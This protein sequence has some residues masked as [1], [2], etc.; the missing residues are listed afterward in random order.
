[1]KYAIYKICKT[2][3]WDVV[4]EECPTADNNFRPDV[5]AVKNNRKIGFEVQFSKISPTDLQDRDRKYSNAGI[6]SYW[7]LKDFFG[8]SEI[9]YW[10]LITTKQQFPDDVS[11]INDPDFLLD[12][13][14]YYF[15]MKN[16]RSIGIDDS[17][18]NL[19]SSKNNSLSL[20]EWVK[21]CL[22]G[23][24]SEYLEQ[25]AVVIKQKLGQ[26]EKWKP[27]LD[28]INE[29]GKSLHSLQNNVTMDCKGYYQYLTQEETKHI[30]NLLQ[31]L[32]EQLV[33]IILLKDENYTKRKTETKDSSIKPDNELEI[34]KKIEILL[35]NYTKS[36]SE[37]SKLFHK[38]IEEAQRKY[39]QTV[40]RAKTIRE[41]PKKDTMSA[42]QKVVF[43]FSHTLPLENNCLSASS[44]NKYQYPIGWKTS[45]V[46]HDAIEFQKKGYG[47][48]IEDY[49]RDPS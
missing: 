38:I 37:F 23:E 7:L 28:Q 32:H 40:N 3:G 16:I 39:L 30:Y 29:K 19:F 44:G 45:I 21:C 12:F 8:H 20:E 33:Q 13:E 42:G 47:K 35:K 6:E 41:M 1:M 14:K 4:T 9:N 10:D 22:T 5:F 43:Q 36:E 11:F 48:I 17:N 25:I 18:E 49:I 2:E 15:V 31:D 26:Y 46:E 24:Y 27:I 34:L